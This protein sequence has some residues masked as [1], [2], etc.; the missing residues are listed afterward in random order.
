MKKI[1]Y[2]IAFLMAA[3]MIMG[4]TLTSFAANVKADKTYFTDASGKKVYIA[5]HLNTSGMAFYESDQFTNYQEYVVSYEKTGTDE[6]YYVMYFPVGEKVYLYNQGTST[7]MTSWLSYGNTNSP[8]VFKF[9]KN[10]QAGTWTCSDNGVSPVKLVIGA[11]SLSNAQAEM[12]SKILY[13]SVDIYTSMYDDGQVFIQALSAVLVTVVDQKTL[14]GALNQIL[15]ILPIGLG[16]LV[17][18]LALRKALAVLQS[19]L[20]QA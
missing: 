14:E 7:N 5:D 15:L 20:H 18:Y 4:F 13:S 16:C 6:L 17:G 10:I 11:S 9:V 12:A 19:L 8:Y 3:I 2:Y 1:K